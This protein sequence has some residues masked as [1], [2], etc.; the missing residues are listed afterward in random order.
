MKA[1]RFFAVLATA[2][3]LAVSCSMFNKSTASSTDGSATETAAAKSTVNS[4]A[5]TAGQTTGESLKALYNAY[6]ANN[7]KLDLTSGTNLLTTAA[8]LTSIGDLKGSDSLYKKS[9]AKGLVLGSTGLVQQQVSNDVTNSL[10]TLA[11]TVANAA[12]G[13]QAAQTA[14]TAANT[15]ANTA[16]TAAGVLSNASAITTAL[17]GIFGSLGSK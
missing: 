4:A 8:L 7:K 10:T 2:S 14:Q 9:F 13:S 11:T 5:Q 16:N 6:M 1:T 15:A 12:A 17:S 3:V